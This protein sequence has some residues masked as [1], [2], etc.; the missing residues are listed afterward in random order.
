MADVA[1]VAAVFTMQD[2]TALGE[3]AFIVPVRKSLTSLV[4]VRVVDVIMRECRCVWVCRRWDISSNYAAKERIFITQRFNLKHFDGSADYGV[5]ASQVLEEFFLGPREF[6]VFVGF[7]GH[8]SNWRD[9][10]YRRITELVANLFKRV[11]NG[12]GIRTGTNILNIA[13]RLNLEFKDYSI[14]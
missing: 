9:F 3:L 7:G 5:F 6:I 14:A 10:S 4:M 8:E 13:I 1:L 2:V 11:E 12:T